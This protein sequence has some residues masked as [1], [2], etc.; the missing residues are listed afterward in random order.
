MTEVPGSEPLLQQTGRFAD[1][2]S[3]RG[4]RGINPCASCRRDGQIKDWLASLMQSAT[5]AP[6]SV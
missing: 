1:S 3:P 5:T 4:L 6:P 2:P